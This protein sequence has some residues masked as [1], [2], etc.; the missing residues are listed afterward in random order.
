MTTAERNAMIKE[1]YEK[2]LLETLYKEVIE[3][4]RK[5]IRVGDIQMKQKIIIENADGKEIWTAISR[6]EDGVMFLLDK[7]YEF[8]D[9]MFSN[10]N[11]NYINSNIREVANQCP[12]TTRAINVLGKN[13]FIPLE[14]DLFSH[15]GLDDY[16]VCK[17]DLFGVLT[18]DMYRNN[19]KNIKP[20]YMWLST[21]HSTS[22][23][24]GSS[25]VM[26]VDGGGGVG[27]DWYDGCGGV[28]PFFILKSDIFVSLAE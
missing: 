21:P 18:Y 16:G 26:Y 8:K 28:R 19:R 11:N 13:S 4:E 17:G 5:K 9:V 6:T 22:S 25:G 14:I 1:I 12:P 2:G 15:D 10:N 27:Y 3:S 20:S 7:E 23:G 24:Y